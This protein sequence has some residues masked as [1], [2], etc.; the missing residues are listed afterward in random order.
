[1]FRM[2]SSLKET[3]GLSYPKSYKKR[4]D[5]LRRLAI[6]EIEA[7]IDDI[8]TKEQRFVGYSTPMHLEDA[9]NYARGQEKGFLEFE[10]PL[11]TFPKA[12]PEQWNGE[13]DHVDTMTG[14]YFLYTGTQ[15]D[16]YSSHLLKRF[17]GAPQFVHAFKKVL[18]PNANVVV[19]VDINKSPVSRIILVLPSD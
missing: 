8:L 16:Q 15:L 10:A 3:L 13:I 7:T 12:T 11:L 18:G 19:S 5:A 17:K 2:I 9:I 1:M 14:E 6:Q 4:I